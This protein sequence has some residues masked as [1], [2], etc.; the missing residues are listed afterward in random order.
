MAGHFKIDFHLP[1]W[2]RIISSWFKSTSKCYYTTSSVRCLM[3][4]DQTAQLCTTTTAM[5]STQQ[6]TLQ[7]TGFV[8]FPPPPF[9][10]L[11]DFNQHI[12]TTF[13]FHLYTSILVCTWFHEL[14]VEAAPGL[15]ALLQ[16]LLHDLDVGKGT[17]AFWE[18]GR[19]PA[20]AVIVAAEQLALWVARHIA[21]GCLHKTP[22]QKLWQDILQA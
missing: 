3:S 16:V 5:N 11:K 9:S 21:E 8:F 10:T 7:V 15:F 1:C 22:T 12:F 6:L 18:S 13:S 17:V 19:A 2:L 14:L 20:P 4:G